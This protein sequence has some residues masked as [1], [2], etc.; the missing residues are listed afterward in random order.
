MYK[1]HGEILALHWESVRRTSAELYHV[2]NHQMVSFFSKSEWSIFTHIKS[3]PIFCV[4]VCAI[5]RILNGVIISRI[6]ASQILV[7]RIWASHNLTFPEFDFPDFE[8]PGFWLSRILAFRIFASCIV[9]SRILTLTQWDYYFPDFGFLFP[10][11]DLPD[12]EFPQFWLSRILSFPDFRF[13][14]CHFKDFDFN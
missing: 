1:K 5:P 3:E 4:S 10:E 12:F 9:T 6:L 8:F 14:Y 11:F 7:S 2:C 13:R